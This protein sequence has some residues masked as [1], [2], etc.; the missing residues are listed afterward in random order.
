MPG[1]FGSGGCGSWQRGSSHVRSSSY[2]KS[3]CPRSTDH[4]HASGVPRAS[5]QGA[6][7]HGLLP[8]PCACSAPGVQR[9]GLR[10]SVGTGP[11]RAASSPRCPAR[12]SG[13]P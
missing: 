4:A 11:A 7:E 2:F 1:A 3:S 5:V 8:P 6:G 9:P 12:P 13:M 10:V